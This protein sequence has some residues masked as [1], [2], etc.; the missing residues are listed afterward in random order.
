MN[1]LIAKFI[2][3][4]CSAS[5]LCVSI[6]QAKPKDSS[7]A[8]NAESENIEVTPDHASVTSE[9]LAAIYVL[10][11]LC[12]SYGFKDEGYKNGYAEL[13]KENLPDE[14][15]PVHA[16]EQRAKQKEFKKFIAEAEQDA[17]KAGDEQNKEICQEISTLSAAKTS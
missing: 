15:D 9:E 7:S 8:N 10:S 5:L 4:V 2:L 16:L 14:R 6:A 3:G 13:V 17:Q 11:K 1:Q 12:K